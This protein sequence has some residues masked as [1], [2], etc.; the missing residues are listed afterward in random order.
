MILA[1]ARQTSRE[2]LRRALPAA[3][4]GATLLLAAASRALL[5]P[6]FASADAEIA[7]VA[8]SAVLLAGLASAVLLGTP[9]VARDLE[10]GTLT[11]VLSKPAGLA[12]YVL[13]RG[14]GLAASC[15]ALSLAVAAAVPPIFAWIGGARLG[16]ILTSYYITSCAA[17][18]LAVLVVGSAAIAVSSF[19]SR[20][21]GPLLVVML[22]VAGSVGLP[23]PLAFLLPDFRHFGIA[24]R[25]A[26]PLGLLAA[27][28]LLF[29]SIFL[30][31]AYIVLSIRPPMRGQG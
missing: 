1:I 7:S 16:S 27:Y 10:R 18:L 31:V 8:V 29:S 20:A 23:A 11:L 26:P 30:L 21:S 12:A 15:A 3:I 24:A 6:S 28:G 9:L 25:P 19:A 4:F 2:A 13:G 5:P 22:L 14:L 17:C